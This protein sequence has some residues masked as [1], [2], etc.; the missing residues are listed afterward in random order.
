MITLLSLSLYF[1]FIKY[2]TDSLLKNYIS[3][4]ENENILKSVN[5]GLMGGFLAINY[6]LTNEKSFKSIRI[7]I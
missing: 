2:G 5:M 3:I 7:F 6:R 1:I 4:V